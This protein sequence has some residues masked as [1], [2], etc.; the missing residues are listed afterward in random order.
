MNMYLHKGKHVFLIK[1]NFEIICMILF[2]PFKTIYIV[3][4]KDSKIYLHCI[5]KKYFI[6]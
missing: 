1:K 6:Y 3:N 5:P 2:L 4:L